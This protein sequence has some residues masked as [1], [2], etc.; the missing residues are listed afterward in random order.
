MRRHWAAAIA[1]AL[2]GATPAFAQASN[3]LTLGIDI[4]SARVLREISGTQELR[5]PVLGAR[6]SVSIRRLEIE[7]H[8]AEASLTPE[9]GSALSGEDLIS[10]RVV[11]RAWVSPWLALGAGAQLRGF[12]SPSGTA[13][14]Q[15]L[16]V[17]SRFRGELI[18]DV[19]FVVAD[20]WFAPAAETNVQG[21]GTGARGGEAGVLLRVP[22]TP[23]ALHLS[24]FADRGTYA[25][26]GGEYFEGVRAALV[27]D[28]LFDPPAR[29]RPSR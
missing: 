25:N 15:R 6:G 3:P 12:V 13:R 16:E 27:L 7:A 2:C 29:S 17:H 4:T 22:G 14:W 11:A 26:G 1:L 24:Y 28:R 8:Y 19:A 9:S 5:G 18:N 20:L 23:T 21:G 10:A